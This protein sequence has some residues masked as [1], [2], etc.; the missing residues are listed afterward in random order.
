MIVITELSCL[1][2]YKNWINIVNETNNR[3][4]LKCRANVP[5]ATLFYDAI[6]ETKGNRGT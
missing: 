2:T 4:S 3:K 5:Q 6:R 1:F